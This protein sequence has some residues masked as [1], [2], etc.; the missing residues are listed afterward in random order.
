[1]EDT[2]IMPIYQRIAIDI[3][4]LIKIETI[5]EDEVI[6]GRSSLA[7]KYNVSPETIR[8]AIKVLED[9]EV[10]KSVKGTGSRVLSRDK[11]IKFIERYSYVGNLSG[12]KKN[13]IETFK[14]IRELEEKALINVSKIIDYSGRLQGSTLTSPLEFHIPNNSHLINKTDDEV[15]FWQNTG[16]TIVG[17]KR[18][19]DMIISP[20]PY[21]RFGEGDTLFIIAHIDQNNTIEEFIGRDQS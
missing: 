5:K 18:S 17:V 7:G 20:G 15:K 21:I 8:R 16:G 12:Y 14:K 2:E 1:M 3:A 11:A 19:E 9:V 6:Y 10:V 4:K 13:L